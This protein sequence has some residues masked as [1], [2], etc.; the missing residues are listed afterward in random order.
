MKILLKN[1]RIVDPLRKYD[2][3]FDIFIVDGFI[4]SIGGLYWR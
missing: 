4:Q 1:S 3:M 2:G